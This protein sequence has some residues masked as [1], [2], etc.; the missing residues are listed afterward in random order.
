MT[1][2]SIMSGSVMQESGINNSTENTKLKRPLVDPDVINEIPPDAYPSYSSA[3][4]QAVAQF[5]RG[6]TGG[7]TSGVNTADTA[8][9]VDNP[10]INKLE[11]LLEKMEI[12]PE[13][14]IEKVLENHGV[15]MDEASRIVDALMQGKEY[16]KDYSL[17]KG[18]SV[19]FKTRLTEDQ[20]RTLDVLENYNPRLPMT[21]G[22]ITAQQ[23]LANSI[24][25]FRTPTKEI[26]FS[27]MSH[28]EKIKWV[29]KLPETVTN[30]MTAKLSKFDR[31]V[32]DVMDEGIIENF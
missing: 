10:E 8:G 5:M 16:T 9:T 19:R 11:E 26:P 20:N 29:E 31:L 3:G 18:C 27:A 32:L 7:S 23:N 22:S 15:S 24:V 1:K 13:L 28:Q 25:S 17:T 14:T 21:A 30:L 2:K 4:A 12:A 6:S